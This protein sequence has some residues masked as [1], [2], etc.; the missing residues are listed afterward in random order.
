M[1]GEIEV[2]RASSMR[3]SRFC[4]VTDPSCKEINNAG[5]RDAKPRDGLLKKSAW[6]GVGYLRVSE[7]HSFTL[8]FFMRNLEVGRL[9]MQL[10]R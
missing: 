3:R 10:S 7:S 2:G 4:L 6:P 5:G 1:R 8:L 9:I